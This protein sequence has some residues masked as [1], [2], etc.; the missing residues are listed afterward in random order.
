MKKK[1][2]FVAFSLVA[3]LTFTGCNKKPKPT[4][5]ANS[6]IP[7]T[8]PVVAKDMSKFISCVFESEKTITGYN[9][10]NKITGNNMVMYQKTIDYTID[11]STKT[12]SYSD[13]EQKVDL[14]SDDL[15]VTTSRTSY[16]TSDNNKYINGKLVDDNY[17]LPS[18]V[19]IFNLDD[20]YLSA[21]S[22][23]STT[24]SDTLNATIKNDKLSVFFLDKT[25]TNMKDV[26]VT[27]ILEN[28]KISSFYAKYNSNNRLNEIT[29]NYKQA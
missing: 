16:E 12:S 8:T 28:D 29:I 6:E 20:E 26:E 14:Y 9:Q 7:S 3:L 17:K 27:I 24:T 13:E 2:I 10:V 19:L 22:I 18:F 1:I 5:S 25:F 23:T 21:P 4:E 11:R 15:G